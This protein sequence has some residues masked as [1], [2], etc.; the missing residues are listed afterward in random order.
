MGNRRLRHVLLAVLLAALSVW[1]YCTFTVLMDERTKNEA[2]CAVLC[3]MYGYQL[4]SASGVSNNLC[5][6]YN[7]GQRYRFQYRLDILGGF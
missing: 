3:D 4:F 6:C 7:K 5:S 1:S 2:R